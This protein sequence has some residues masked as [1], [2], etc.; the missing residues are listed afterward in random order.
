MSTSWP[1]PPNLIGLGPKLSGQLPPR[2]LIR[3][4]SHGSHSDK[5]RITST[6]TLWA[7][8]DSTNSFTHL[9]PKLHVKAPARSPGDEEGLDIEA[10]ASAMTF[11]ASS[12][13]QLPSISYRTS[14]TKFSGFLPVWFHFRTSQ[15]CVPDVLLSRKNISLFPSSVYLSRWRPAKTPT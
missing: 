6:E 11:S 9:M 14:H 12:R 13:S 3:F 1:N 10:E 5:P 8:N 2:L 4:K 7:E 15:Q